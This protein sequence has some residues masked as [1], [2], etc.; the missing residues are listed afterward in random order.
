[1][2]PA[3]PKKFGE[4]EVIRKEGSGGFGAAFLA[5]NP[6]TGKK[7]IIKQLDPLES[8]H[9]TGLDEQYFLQE[10]TILNKLDSKYI[11]KLL[12]WNFKVQKPWIAIQYFPGTTLW[13]Y[14]EQ[15]S[16]ASE[17]Q[18]FQMAHDIFSALEHA[19]KNKVVHRDL[20]PKN[21][22]LY[23]E[24]ARLID[25]GLSRFTDNPYQTRRLMGFPGFTAPEIARGNP[26]TSYDIFVAATALTAAGT[27]RMPW[28]V[29]QDRFETSI[30]NDAPD[31]KGLSKNQ[32]ALLTAMHQKDPKAR[33]GA[34]Q[35]LKMIEELAPSTAGVQVP[36][37]KVVK[38]VVPT[39][40][41]KKAEELV[42]KVIE[43]K[44]DGI[45]K[46][47]SPGP[48]TNLNV[49][50]WMKNRKELMILGF[51]TGG[52]AWII[53]AIASIL[54]KAGKLSYK[55]RGLYAIN[56]TIGYGSI[57]LLSPFATTYWYRKLKKKKLLWLMIAQ[58]LLLI[59]FFFGAAITPDGGTLPGWVAI[60]WMALWAS[61]SLLAKDLY[62]YFAIRDG[63]LVDDSAKSAPSIK[64]NKSENL[65][66]ESS[67]TSNPD[68]TKA[69]A[70][71]D[72]VEQVF[73]ALLAK[74]GR[75]KFVIGVESNHVKGIFFQ[76][77]SEPDGAFTIEAA[78]DLSVRPKITIE[79][80][81]NLKSL[82]WDSPEEGL[83][84]FIQFLSVEESNVAHM[85]RLFANTLK[86]GYGL[87][88]GT[89]KVIQ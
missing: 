83:P 44:I 10:A 40:P 66:E 20:N 19:H 38:P 75:K 84:N 60:A 70:N 85:S 56:L 87:N 43:Q 13:D 73:S 1:M 12:D 42:N 28:K 16:V 72:E 78:A 64:A 82:G 48:S 37:R 62:K 26:D 55:N 67:A 61:T 5:K 25:F 47:L 79:Q 89:F 2:S 54:P 77:Y 81:A 68:Y 58:Y 6:K 14:L 8:N 65:V 49:V 11:S 32:V 86:D 41:V 27:G 76:G 69:H 31:Y 3:M 33:I 22:I 4:W 74:I 57:G 46:K 21:I 15:G 30:Q 34:S 17:S 39:P 29:G 88:I 23:Y 71:W 59:S 63:L 51:L 35:A 36:Q 80:R 52:W 50:E 18:W 9:M 53:Y 45:N 24:G 7:A